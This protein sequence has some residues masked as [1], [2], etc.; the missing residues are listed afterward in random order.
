MI[1]RT[2]PWPPAAAD[3]ECND[4]L[5]VAVPAL[6]A[7]RRDPHI[8]I[9]TMLVI[10]I[11]VS[12]FAEGAVITDIQHFLFVDRFYPTQASVCYIFIDSLFDQTQCNTSK[13]IQDA[14]DRNR[15]PALRRSH[16]SYNS[17]KND[18]S[19]VSAWCTCH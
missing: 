13:L 6:L 2:C 9:N 12:I 7:C 8:L 1:I 11:K 16:R 5:I 14:D 4:L 18:S 3:E 10:I 15:W 19:R 17:V